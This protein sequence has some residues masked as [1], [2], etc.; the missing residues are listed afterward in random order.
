M[1]EA[2]RSDFLYLCSENLDFITSLF[3]KKERHKLPKCTKTAEE[4]LKEGNKLFVQEEH[5]HQAHASILMCYCKS[6]AFALPDS[7][8]LLSAYM[9]R[10][11]FLMHIY[12][13]KESLNDID[14]ALKLCK[15]NELQRG[16][17]LCRR[18]ECLKKS[19]SSDYEEVL[20]EIEV[21]IE[22]I[23]NTSAE[24]HCHNGYMIEYSFADVVV[25]MSKTNEVFD[26]KYLQDLSYRYMLI[27]WVFF[28]RKSP[29]FS[30]FKNVKKMMNNDDAIFVG[31]LLMKFMKT[32][33]QVLGSLNTYDSFIVKKP[34]NPNMPWDERTVYS[35][36]FNSLINHSCYPNVHR[37][38]TKY[39]ESKVY[40]LQKIKKGTQICKSYCDMF[41]LMSKSERQEYLKLYGIDCDCPACINDWPCVPDKMK[42]EDFAAME[43]NETVVPYT[44]SRQLINTVLRH[45]KQEYGQEILEEISEILAVAMEPLRVPSI[46]TCYLIIALHRVIK[47]IHDQEKEELL[48]SCKRQF[49]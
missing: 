7:E 34:S 48:K 47:T 40:A 32:N 22:S 13:F 38:F 3:K 14:R 35:S 20:E 21:W 16:K 1:L 33:P 36:P 6:V 31:S 42:D 5:D 39:G 45:N 11:A 37:C 29:F 25:L 15:C 46:L 12:K 23:R 27:F 26:R 18:L 10:S 24:V 28:V 44:R 49:S 41:C 9:N 43:G 30:R 19:N 4:A 8:Q 2:E 17:L